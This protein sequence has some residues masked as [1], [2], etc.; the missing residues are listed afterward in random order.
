MEQTY[1]RE[2]TQERRVLDRLLEANGGWIKKQV[3]VREMFLTK[4]GR[5]IHTLENRYGWHIEHSPFTDEF[6][7]KSYRIVPVASEAT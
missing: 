3:F 7:F 6:G 1:P 4:A 2:G 5:A